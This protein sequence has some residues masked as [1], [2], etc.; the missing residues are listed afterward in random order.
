MDR[1]F[2][3]GLKVDAL[4][5]VYDWEREIL[6][7]LEFDIE[8]ATDIRPAAASDELSLTLD[9]FSISQAITTLVKN[10]SFKL[11][12]SLAEAVS[13]LIREKFG[14]CWVKVKVSKP[15]AVPNTRNVAV[16]IERG[17]LSSSADQI[18][19]GVAQ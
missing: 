18:V 14:V 7:P 13:Q 2:I 19:S 17:S 8:M 5:G 10:A 11:I 16:Q 15:G 4:I 9:Y 1:V 12:E 6:Q 3:E